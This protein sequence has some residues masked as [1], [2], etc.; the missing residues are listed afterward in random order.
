MPPFI[1]ENI[2]AFFAHALPNLSVHRTGKLHGWT[3][4]RSQSISESYQAAPNL[5]WYYLF[6]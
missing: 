6:K 1:D 4:S 3:S 2:V 5:R